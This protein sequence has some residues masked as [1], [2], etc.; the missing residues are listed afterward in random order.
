MV[1]SD[2]LMQAHMSQYKLS[3]ESG[4]GQATISDLCSGKTSIEKCAAGTLYRIAKVLGTS[5]DYLIES[6]A[7]DREKREYR[8][9]F[10]TFRGNLCHLVKD[11]GDIEFI[12]ET[13]ENNQIRSLFEKKWYPE[14]MYTLAMLDYLSRINNLPIC[15]NYDDI[16]VHKLNKPLYTTDVLLKSD[17]MD[18][19]VYK[20]EAIDN[21]IPEFL[22]FNIVEGGIRDVV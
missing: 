21:A 7:K 17:M 19:D 8:P 12:I 11:K 5:V 22:R 4:V 1:I 6:D 20:K 18:T 14:C 13:L 3:K 16:R 2:L 10:D 15:S 9:T